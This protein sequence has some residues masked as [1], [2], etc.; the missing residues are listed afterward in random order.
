MQ[1]RADLESMLQVVEVELVLLLLEQQEHGSLWH[2]HAHAL[3]PF[4]L[5][6]DCQDALVKVHQ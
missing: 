2:R 1:G 5:P 3:Q 4:G 6:D